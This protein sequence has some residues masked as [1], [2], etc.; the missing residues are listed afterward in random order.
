MNRKGVTMATIIGYVIVLLTLIVLLILIA[1]W[2]SQGI[3]LI[4]YFARIFE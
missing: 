3:G 1:Q 2:R 4:D